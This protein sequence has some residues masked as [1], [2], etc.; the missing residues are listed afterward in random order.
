MEQNISSQAVER[1]HKDNLKLIECHL[2]WCKVTLYWNRIT[3]WFRP[4]VVTGSVL[5]HISLGRIV[6]EVRSTLLDGTTL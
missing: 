3:V 2:I 5:R 4:V 1:L 6:L